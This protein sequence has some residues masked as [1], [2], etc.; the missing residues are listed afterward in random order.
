MP[1][2]P[3]KLLTVEQIREELRNYVSSGETSNDRARRQLLLV[4]HVLNMS[5]Y[6]GQQL[7]GIRESERKSTI[8]RLANK[9]DD[10]IKN[11]LPP[12]IYLMFDA[13]IAGWATFGTAAEHRLDFIF[14]VS[15]ID[16]TNDISR[17]TD[18]DA[19]H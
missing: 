3:P 6:L 10:F 14:P 9:R 5:F 12:A 4:D 1:N 16:T 18:K 11:D 19:F 17:R 7:Q 2:K 15:E 8:T 13:L